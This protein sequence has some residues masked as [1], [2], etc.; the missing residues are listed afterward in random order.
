MTPSS[1]TASSATTVWACLAMASAAVCLFTGCKKSDAGGPQG[2]FA[3][4]V[5]A[6]KAERQPVTERLSI[7]GNVMANEMVDLK[8]EVDGRVVQIHF[9]EGQRVESGQMLVELNSG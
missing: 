2:G 3:T 7:V 6:V 1:S 5:I 4:Q 9:E 8:T